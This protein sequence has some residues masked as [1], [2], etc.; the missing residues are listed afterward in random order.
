MCVCEQNLIDCS[1]M[2]DNHGC[3]G[4]LMDNAFRY[5]EANNRGIDTEESYPY[6]AHDEL[7]Q[8]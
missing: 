2:Y 4:G 1:T 8:I 5:A 6:Q 7:L 3:K